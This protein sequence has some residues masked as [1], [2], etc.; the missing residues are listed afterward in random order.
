MQRKK[1]K[2]RSYVFL[3]VIQFIGARTRV[4]TW[5]SLSLSLFFFFFFFAFWAT[6]IA[7]GSFQA[8][9]RIRAA[10]AG[11]HHS[12]SNSGSKPCLQ[13]TPQLTAALDPQPSER[14]QEMNW[15]PHVYLSDSFPLRHSGNSGGSLDSAQRIIYCIK[16]RAGLTHLL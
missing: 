16:A 1:P 10:A 14:G 12:H 13:P 7:Y 6:R 2:L 3:S 5:V 8:W 9:G 15:H 4:R 11:L